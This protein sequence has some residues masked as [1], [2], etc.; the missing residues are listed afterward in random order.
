MDT[1]TKLSVLADA[2]K[3]EASCSSGGD[4]RR[5]EAGDQ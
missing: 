3:Y 1:R 2:A 4:N 5:D